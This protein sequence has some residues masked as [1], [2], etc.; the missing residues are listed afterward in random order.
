MISVVI[1][2]VA[3]G[4]LHPAEALA[5]WQ[6]A[7]A[8]SSVVEHCV[9]IAG[10]ASSILA[11]PTIFQKGRQPERVGR[12]FSYRLLVQC[13][14]PTVILTNVRIHEHGRREP[15]AAVFMD[16]GSIMS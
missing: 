4:G 9:D 1:E 16:S 5:T 14:S 15:H 12:P 13:A 3:E 8:C 2:P 6:P 11:T 10:V 7:W